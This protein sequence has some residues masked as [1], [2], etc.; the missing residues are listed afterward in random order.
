[1]ISFMCYLLTAKPVAGV[2]ITSN[3]GSF[4]ASYLKLGDILFRFSDFSEKFKL[5]ITF[6]YMF[7]TFKLL[8]QLKTRRCLSL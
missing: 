7:Y 6:V 1:M 5:G 8:P 2:I 3:K 4:Q